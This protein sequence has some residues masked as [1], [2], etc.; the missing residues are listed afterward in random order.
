MN[1]GDNKIA[2]MVVKG[3]IRGEFTVNDPMLLGEGGE[4]ALTVY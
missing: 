2:L 4:V 3:T 1:M